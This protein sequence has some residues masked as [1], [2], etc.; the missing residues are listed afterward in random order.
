MSPLRFKLFGSLMQP[1][2]HQADPFVFR[3]WSSDLQWIV[4]SIYHCHYSDYGYINE[5]A[6]I[7]T[8]QI[9]ARAIYF[10]NCTSTKGKE[11]PI[12]CGHF[13]G[14]SKRNNLYLINCIRKSYLYL[15]L[16]FFLLFMGFPCIPPSASSLIQVCNGRI[17]MIWRRLIRF[18]SVKARLSSI[19]IS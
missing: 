11:K 17:S 13:L 15:Y 4:S 8:T 10:Y 6:E 14:V 19:A 2:W 5:I 18:L 1:F 16:S 3:A 12:L 9:Q 7:T